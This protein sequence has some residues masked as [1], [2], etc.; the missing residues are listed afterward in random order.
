MEK[1]QLR[2]DANVSLRPRGEDRLGTRTELKNINS[3]RFVQH[4]IE[5]EIAAP[6]RDPR[7]RR[8]RG[9]GDPAVGRRPRPVGVDA[10]QG[11]GE[12]LPLLPRSGSA[13]AGRRCGAHGRHLAELPELPVARFERYQQRPRALGRRRAH[14]DRGSR[15]R[16]L[17]RRA[18]SL[19]TPAPAAGRT[20]AN[21][22]LTELLGAL[23]ADGT[24]IAGVADAAGAT[25]SALVELVEN[26]TISGKIGKDI[27]DECY[28]T[29]A[30]PPRSSIGAGSGRSPDET[31]LPEIVRSRGR[32]EPETGRRLPGRQGPAVRVLRRSGDEGDAGLGRIQ[33]S[34]ADRF[35]EFDW[36]ANVPD[37]DS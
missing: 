31:V 27:F 5:H 37:L 33:W 20:L 3:F 15:A 11:G 28:R 32:G 21:W 9:P 16:R 25:L 7:R 19:R 17:L 1:G 14:A 13:A 4:A 30:A 35:C 6:D 18:R 29:S 22:M 23:N 24:H 8:P 36:A 10:L 34:A 26:G 12:R 2:C